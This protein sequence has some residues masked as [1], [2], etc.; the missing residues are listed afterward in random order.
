MMRIYLERALK[1]R[2]VPRV[3]QYRGKQSHARRSASTFFGSSSSARVAAPE[4]LKR[5]SA[6]I[7][8]RPEDVP[9]E[10]GRQIGAHAAVRT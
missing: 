9:T 6:G 5:T 2:H 4:R 8:R 3:D 10:G 7:E 1:F